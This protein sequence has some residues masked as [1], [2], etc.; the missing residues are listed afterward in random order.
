V[1]VP[2]DGAQV[3]EAALLEWLAPL[4]AR[5]KLPRRVVF[6]QALPKSGYGKVPKNL[7]KA[8]LAEDGVAF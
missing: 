1:C 4:L 5:Y 2:R 7:V 8:R 3:T 6:W